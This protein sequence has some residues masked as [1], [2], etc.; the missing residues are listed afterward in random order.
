MDSQL[1]KPVRQPIN[2]YNYYQFSKLGNASG[3]PQ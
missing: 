1:Q 2:Q 3:L